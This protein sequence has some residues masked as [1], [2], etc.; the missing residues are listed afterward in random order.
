MKFKIPALLA[1]TLLAGAAVAADD[2]EQAAYYRSLTAMSPDLA[3]YSFVIEQYLDARCGRPQ[4]L[5]HVQAVL[6]SNDASSLGVTLALK[7]GDK[8]KAKAMLERLPCE[9]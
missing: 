3:A 9:P 6:R 4:S 2:A 5:K 7:A 1:F 8:A